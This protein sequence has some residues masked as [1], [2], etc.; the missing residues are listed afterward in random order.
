MSNK[1]AILIGVLFLGSLTFHHALA[2]TIYLKSGQKITGEIIERNDDYLII[3]FKGSELP[4]YHNEIDRIEEDQQELQTNSKEKK[5]SFLQ[6]KTPT[7][8]FQE[9]S[10]S[11]ILISSKDGERIGSGFILSEEGLF[12]TNRHVLMGVSDWG[13]G[14]FQVFVMFLDGREY[15]ISSSISFSNL[16]DLAIGMI[17]GKNIAVKKVQLGNS[18]MTE[19]G[20]KVFTIGAPLGLEFTLSDGLISGFREMH[21]IATGEK[22]FQ[23]TASISPG[24]SGGPLINIRGEVIGINTAQKT[25]GQ[26]L[27]FAITSNSLKEYIGRLKDAASG[28]T[29]MSSEYTESRRRLNSA[30]SRLILP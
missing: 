29:Y 5:A 22:V 24:N 3:L 13:P 28:A 8:I 21:S 7:E 27:N 18:T 1:L 14:G 15:P 20:D 4:Y 25:Q 17:E 2:E 6:P 19:I 12:V 23:T 30:L 11:V 26:N 10:D 9:V 16:D